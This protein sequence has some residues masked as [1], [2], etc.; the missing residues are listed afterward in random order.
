MLAMLEF[1]ID[2]SVAITLLIIQLFENE[3]EKCQGYRGVRESAPDQ[4]ARP[5]PDYGHRAQR[6]GL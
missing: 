6:A 2:A 1:L 4:E 5:P 3:Q